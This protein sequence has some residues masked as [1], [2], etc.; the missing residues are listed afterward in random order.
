MTTTLDIAALASAI[1][2]PIALVIIFL[3]FR[4]EIPAIAKG[5]AGRLTKIEVGGI[6]LELAKAEPFDPDW[7]KEGTLDLRHKAASI[8]VNDSTAGNFLSQLKAGGSADYAIVNLG[9]GGDWLSSRLYIMAI[10]FERMKG[11]NGIVFLETTSNTRKKFIGWSEP[12]KVRWAFAQRFPWLE[13]AYSEAYFNALPAANIVSY[14][15]R[16]GYNYDPDSP[17]PSIGLLQKFLEKIQAPPGNPPMPGEEND[18]ISL[19]PNDNTQERAVWLNAEILEDILGEALITESIQ[20]GSDATTKEQQIKR[21]LTLAHP[22][23][24]VVKEDYRFD[25]L[26]KREKLLEQ[27]LSK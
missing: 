2:Y 20:S 7:V 21:C 3:L 5:I 19:P 25:Y 15:G 4:K 12:E 13:A 1:L 24:A 22:F 23:I 18:W 8:N 9:S 16:L 10:I 14:T 17:S 6:S 11:V 26:V 27:L